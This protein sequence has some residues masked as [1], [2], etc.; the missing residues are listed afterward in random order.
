MSKRFVAILQHRPE[1]KG[2]YVT[3]NV[4]SGHSVGGIEYIIQ[5][6]YQPIEVKFEKETA[7]YWVFVARRTTF[8]D[9]SPTETILAATCFNE[10]NYGS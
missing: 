2:D 1:F 4:D 7:I 3:T 10:E 6:I 9:G 8:S 5:D